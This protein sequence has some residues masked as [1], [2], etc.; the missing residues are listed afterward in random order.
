MSNNGTNGPTERHKHLNYWTLIPVGRHHASLFLTQMCCGCAVDSDWLTWRGWAER[1][2]TNAHGVRS[3]AWAITAIRRLK[4]CSGVGGDLRQRLASG[5]RWQY[6]RRRLSDQ[7]LYPCDSA[8]E[9]G[10]AINRRAARGPD[11]IRGRQEIRDVLVRANRADAKPLWRFAKRFELMKAMIEAAPRRA[12]RRSAFLSRNAD[13]WRQSL[14]RRGVIENLLR[15]GCGPFAAC[16]RSSCGTDAEFRRPLAFRCG[17]ARPEFIYGER[18]PKV[19]TS[20]G[21]HRR[22]HRRGLLTRHYADMLWCETSTPTSPKR[23]VR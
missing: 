19:F 8:A 14:C 7:N 22:G 10:E 18:T 11:R 1:L 13:I 6:R 4:W 17:S 23:R 2:W 5:C 9:F 20:I 21:R 15:R 12:F 3:G 16:Q